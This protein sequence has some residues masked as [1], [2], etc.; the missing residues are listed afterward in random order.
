MLQMAILLISAALVG[1]DQLTKWLAMTFLQTG[2][3]V[4]IWDGVFSLKYTV[5]TGAAWNLFD[6]QWWLLTGLTSVMLAGVLIVLLSG[7]FR[8]HRMANIGGVLVFAGG[9]GNLIDRFV[10]GYVVDFLKFDFIDFPIFNVA[11]CFIVIGSITLFIY[12]VFLYSD[13]SESKDDSK[14]KDEVLTSGNDDDQTV[15][16]DGG[17]EA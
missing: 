7:R 5:N 10:H 8:R 11:D 15:G 17:D 16:G 12:F 13:H 3:P 1:V 4:V 9:I 14:Q 2:G 6:G